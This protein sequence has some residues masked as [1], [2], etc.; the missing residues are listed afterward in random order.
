MVNLRGKWWSS[1]R[2]KNLTKNIFREEREKEKDE[3][4]KQE[5]NAAIFSGK[6]C[7]NNTAKHFSAA[8]GCRYTKVCQAYQ[9][10]ELRTLTIGG[11]VTVRLTS[12][13]TGL[14]L[15]KQVKLLFTLI[16]KQSS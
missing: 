2:Q 16:H 4:L 13:L 10:L 12:C 11:S 15:T 14:D 6:D 7:R 8:N 3:N 9:Y 1:E 5:N